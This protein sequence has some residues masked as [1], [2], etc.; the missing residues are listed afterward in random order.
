MPSACPKLHYHVLLSSTAA[1]GASA[2]VL[3]IDCFT[4]AGLKEFYVWN[5]GLDTLFPKFVNNGIEFPVT[6]IMEI[7]LWAWTEAS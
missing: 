4:T 2:F 1:V 5:L 3:G 7:E 6:Q